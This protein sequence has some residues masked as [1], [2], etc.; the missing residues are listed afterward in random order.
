VAVIG[1]K[2]YELDGPIAFAAWLG[3]HALLMS[4]VRERKP[5]SIGPGM[6]LESPSRF[7]FWIGATKDASSRVKVRKAR[8]SAMRQP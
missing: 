7:R 4:E 6:I 8:V 3:V 5:S 1:K 2:R